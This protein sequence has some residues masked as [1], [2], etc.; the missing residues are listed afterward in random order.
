MVH[1]LDV[2]NRL[3]N[4]FDRLNMS[5][6]SN[7]SGLFINSDPQPT[8]QDTSPSQVQSPSQAQSH[9][10]SL[11]A[12][13]DRSSQPETPYRDDPMKMDVP[14]SYRHLTA[15]HKVLLWPTIYVH[16]L[17]SGI[18]AAT[19]LQYVLQEGTPWF[20]NLEMAKYPQ[21]LPYDVCLPCYALGNNQPGQAARVAFPSLS[22]EYMQQYS[23]VYFNTFNVIYPILNRDNFQNETIPAIQRHGYGDGDPASVI[24]L[25]VFALGKVAIEGTYGNPI[26]FNNNCASGIRGGSLERPPGLEIFN[27]A[28]RRIGFIVSQ[29]TLE[30]VQILLLQAVYTEACA[31]HIDFWRSTV[32]ASMACQVLIK[33]AP[34]D[35][36]SDRGDLVKRAYWTCNLTENLY[37]LDLDLPQTGISELED[38]VPLPYFHTDVQAGEDVA[39][40][41]SHFQYHFLAMIALKRLISR[42]HAALHDATSTTGEAA[43]DHTCPPVALVKELAHQLESWRQLLPRQLQWSDQARFDFPSVDVGSTHTSGNLFTSD[44]GPVPI[45]HRYN[46]DVVTAQLRTRFYYA[47]FMIYRPFVY[48][49]LHFPELMTKADVDCCALALQSAC[50]WPLAMAPPKDKK[51]L[52]PYLFAWTQN[53]VGILLILR[54]TTVNEC[55]GKIASERVNQEEMD[56]TARMLLDWVRD[57]RQV[58][59]IAEWAWRLLDPLYNNRAFNA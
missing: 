49:A 5:S 13:S 46:L 4:K 35:W 8:S 44:Q 23:D 18:A 1:I 27:E 52:V 22:S 16:L 24:A 32:A 20:I 7:N 55:L 54:M 6:P 39:D 12:S 2:L 30:N 53:F 47:R 34:L 3:E 31:R 9:V 21:S 28:R 57:V 25:L 37:H 14:K 19:D 42:I 11:P 51:R 56:F 10:L 40:E 43:V 15:A 26:S 36:S 48:K 33:C 17:N 59:G 58:D 38:H 45:N 50:R 41:R 29:C